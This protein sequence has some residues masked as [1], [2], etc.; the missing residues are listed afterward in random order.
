VYTEQVSSIRR[1][2]SP[3]DGWFSLVPLP[4]VKQPWRRG[5]LGHLHHGDNARGHK[6]G[7]TEISLRLT[8]LSFALPLRM[9]QL[10]P[11]RKSECSQKACSPTR[12]AEPPAAPLAALSP[13]FDLLYARCPPFVLPRL[14]VSF[15]QLSSDAVCLCFP[16]RRDSRQ[17]R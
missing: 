8:P 12:A 11:S 5:P 10:F 6:D 3:Y 1:I 15:T 16:A 13:V 14:I 17:T 7:P 4:W 9:R 2:R